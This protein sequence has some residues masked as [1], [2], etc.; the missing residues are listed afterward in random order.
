MRR[1]AIFIGTIALAVAALWFFAPSGTPPAVAG[2]MTEP[3]T[4][5]QSNEAL[6]GP[7]SRDRSPLGAA[8]PD[9]TEESGDPELA[10]HAGPRIE[11]LD[12]RGDPIPSAVAIHETS[13]GNLIGFPADGQGWIEIPPLLAANEIRVTAPGFLPNVLYGMLQE[14]RIVLAEAIRVQVEITDGWQRLTEGWPG[15]QIKNN[16]DVQLVAPRDPNLDIFEDPPPVE[17]R[18]KDGSKKSVELSALEAVLLAPVS[19]LGLATFW[20]HEPGEYTVGIKWELIA[21]KKLSGSL[22]VTLQAVPEIVVRA[23]EMDQYF[24]VHV[25]PDSFAMMLQAFS[26]AVEDR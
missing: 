22:L 19:P 8:I 21:P 7:D 10:V 26:Q 24:R 4:S 25:P 13:P 17:I 5:V 15:I 3:P 1:T 9:A 16:F 18:S 6:S 2:L 11:V 12:V 20:V 14:E 23:D